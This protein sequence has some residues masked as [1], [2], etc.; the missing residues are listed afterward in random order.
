MQRYSLGV[1][2]HQAFEAETEYSQEPLMFHTGDRW[3]KL[4]QHWS[5][6]WRDFGV[7]PHSARK[8]VELVTSDLLRAVVFD[9]SRRIVV[10]T[11]MMQHVV[12]VWG[13]DTPSPAPVEGLWTP[14]ER[15]GGGVPPVPSWNAQFQLADVGAQLFLSELCRS[16]A[17]EDTT[18]ALPLLPSRY[19]PAALH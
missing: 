5:S 9:M 3:H 14:P 17:H 16:L 2:P 8:P 4:Q 1:Q 18:A 15:W 6:S 10:P 13:L 11:L 7:G 19:A 12:Q